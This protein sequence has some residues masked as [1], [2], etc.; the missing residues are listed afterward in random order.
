MLILKREPT[1]DTDRNT[2]AVFREDQVVGYVPF[3]LA[4]S[5]SLILKRDAF[6]TVVGEKDNKGTGYGLEI[7]SYTYNISMDPSLT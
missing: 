6:A 3:N 5:I 1:N 4:P 2:V 7:P